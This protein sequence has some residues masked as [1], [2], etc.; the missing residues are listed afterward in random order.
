[1]INTEEVQETVNKTTKALRKFGYDE[2]FITQ[3]WDEV[4]NEAKNA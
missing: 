1:M 2:V 4:V 3:F